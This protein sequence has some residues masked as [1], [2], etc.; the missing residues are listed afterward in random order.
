MHCFPD[1]LSGRQHRHQ[2]GAH[3]R[4]SLGVQLEQAEQ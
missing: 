4:H 1:D 2:S 3:E